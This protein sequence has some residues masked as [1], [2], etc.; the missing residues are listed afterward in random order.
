MPEL[1]DI[2]VYLE[3]LKPRILGERLDAVRILNPFLLR[4]ADP[5]ISAAPGRRVLQL[6]RLGKRIVI[7][8][9]E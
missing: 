2:T 9:E 6:Q 7:G 3:A 1:P 8:L 5:P 4:S